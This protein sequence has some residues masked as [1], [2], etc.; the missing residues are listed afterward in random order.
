[1]VTNT[2]G[3]WGVR[4]GTLALWV[5]AGASVVFWGLRLAVRPAPIAAPV[6]APAP[7][8]PDAQ[9]LARLLG[10]GPAA[11][12]APAAREPSRFALQG[13]LAGTASGGGA[14]LIAIDNQPA[15]PFR[16]GA[17]VAEGLVVQS[18]GRKQVRLGPPRGGEATV[19]LEVP[20]KGD[21]AT[22]VTTVAP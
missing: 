10:A 18:L 8:A 3:P 14:A 21:G 20:E 4:L 22:G 11:P 7:P 5:L 12:G 19:T 1:M 2:S 15:R 9:A 17:T 6:A 16:L 13:V